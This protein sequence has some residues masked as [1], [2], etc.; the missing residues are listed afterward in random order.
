MGVLPNSGGQALSR[1]VSSTYL[2]V[3]LGALRPVCRAYRTRIPSLPRGGTFIAQHRLSFWWPPAAVFAFGLLAVLAVPVPSPGEE[4]ATREQQIA[5][6]E[7]Q[8]QDLTKK[9]NELK[10]QP[11]AAHASASSRQRHAA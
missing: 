10:G 4:T 11:A 9:L 8:I 3:N 1:L 7:K 2:G 6:I 5:D